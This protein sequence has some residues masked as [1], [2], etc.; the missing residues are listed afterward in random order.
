MFYE[1]Y[2]NLSK[3]LRLFAIPQTYVF[4]EKLIVLSRLP[5]TVSLR[6]SN[7]RHPALYQFRA[8]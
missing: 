4:E 8:W 5:S 2:E 7:C 6:Q 3:R 1:S